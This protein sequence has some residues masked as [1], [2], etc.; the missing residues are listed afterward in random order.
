MRRFTRG[1]V[2][3]AHNRAMIKKTALAM[4]VMSAALAASPAFAAI[5]YNSSKSNTVSTTTHNK[6][7]APSAT[8]T[9]PR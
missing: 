6:K 9:R 4:M 5:N 8:T 7:N 3:E 2:R 1:S